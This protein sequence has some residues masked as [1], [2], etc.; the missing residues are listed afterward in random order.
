MM[1]SLKSC[2]LRSSARHHRAQARN[3]LLV[4]LLSRGLVTLRTRQ[5]GPQSHQN[6][7]ELTSLLIPPRHQRRERHRSSTRPIP[8]PL[9]DLTP[10]LL[11]L[12]VDTRLGLTH[13]LGTPTQGTLFSG[14]DI[15]HNSLPPV[16]TDT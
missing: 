3:G 2:D 14:D 1:F 8:A 5:R 15:S 9:L 4:A 11:H 6:L 12:L 7:V 13:R 16:L 10:D